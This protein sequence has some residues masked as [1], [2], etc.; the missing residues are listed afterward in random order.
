[1]RLSFPLERQLTFLSTKEEVYLPYTTKNL[2]LRCS[3]VI[4]R[5]LEEKVG[6]TQE[7]LCL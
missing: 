4:D 7:S 2:L 3:P 5:R 6:K 1:M